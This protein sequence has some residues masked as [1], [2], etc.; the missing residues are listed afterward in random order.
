MGQETM[1]RDKSEELAEGNTCCRRNRAKVLVVMS[2]AVTLG[3]LGDI[4]LSR[5]MKI[6]GAAEFDTILQAFISAV[7]NPYVIGGVALLASFLILY[8]I[9]LSWEDLSYVLP[10]TAADYILVTVFASFIL[11]EGVPPLRWLGSALVALG[12]FLVARS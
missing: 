12:I 9:S 8:L 10:L 11:Q 1:S 3:A 6:I 7:S 2:V 5:G 4:S